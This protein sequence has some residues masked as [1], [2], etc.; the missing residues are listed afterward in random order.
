MIPC[1]TRPMYNA[2]ALNRAASGGTL[3]WGRWHRAPVALARSS[4]GTREMRNLLKLVAVLIAISCTPTPAPAN[5]FGLFGFDCGGGHNCGCG[6]NG[7][8][9]ASCGCGNC[10]EPACGCNSCCEP[11]CGCNSCCEPCC[12]CGSG[13]YANG[14]QYAGQV[15][16]CGCQSRVPWCPC[17]EYGGGD[18]QGGCGCGTPCGGCCEPACGCSSCG[19]PCCGCGTGCG[20]W[21]GNGTACCPRKC[22]LKNCGFC[23]ACWGF[24]NALT[25]CCPC[26]GCGGEVYWSE[27]HND[28]PYCHDPCNC[29]NEWVGGCGGCGCGSCGCN[30]GCGSCGTCNGACGC[31]GGGFGQN[32]AVNRNTA[33][34]RHY[35]PANRTIAAGSAR[36]QQ[37]PNQ[38]RSY[39]SQPQNQAAPARTASRPT[40]GNPF[41]SNGSPQP[42]PIMW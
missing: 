23:R 4:P 30:N 38:M 10:C 5:I 28:P 21:C 36:P 25:C 6:C 35:A 9:D 12:G 8:C 40:N 17:R 13:C 3:F 24:V 26:S 2:A 7:C 27:W 16:H 42:R 41:R 22:C 29:N 19:E 14:R 33:V 15:F 31:D 18:G 1:A 37:S 34:A 39:A 20:S 11:A 32:G